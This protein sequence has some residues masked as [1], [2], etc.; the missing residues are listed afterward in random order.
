LKTNRAATSR[1]GDNTKRL[2]SLRLD[3]PHAEETKHIHSR[4][5][6]RV[7]PIREVHE[8]QTPAHLE[9]HKNGRVGGETAQMAGSEAHG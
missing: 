7:E 3:W 6:H 9:V 1:E 4:E 2:K 8:S 5:G